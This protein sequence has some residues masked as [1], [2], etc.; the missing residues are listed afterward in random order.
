MLERMPCRYVSPYARL[1]PPITQTLQVSTEPPYTYTELPYT[2][3]ESSYTY[4]EPPYTYMELPYTYTEPP[5]I[6]TEPSYTYTK[7]SYTYTEL[8]Y[9]HTEASYSRARRRAPHKGTHSG[10]LRGERTRFFRPHPQPLS[11]CVGEG[12]RAFPLARL[13]GEGDK[14]GEGKKMRLPA[15]ACAG[16]IVTGSAIACQIGVP[17][18]TA[19]RPLHTVFPHRQES[20][21]TVRN[22][23]RG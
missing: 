23:E 14:G 4:T 21:A 16:K 22:R 17:L 11:Y 1:Q 12:S 15:L 19:V 5:Y 9:T 8:S 13:A 3:T 6:Y 2:Y 10:S 7:L 18:S 20:G